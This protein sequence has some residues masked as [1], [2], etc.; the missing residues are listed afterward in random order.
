MVERKEGNGWNKGIKVLCNCLGLNLMALA[1]MNC[2]RDLDDCD[3]IC[4][5]FFLFYIFAFLLKVVDIKHIHALL[6]VTT[7]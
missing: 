5:Y 2:G 6:G 1:M 4:K 3:N 7:V